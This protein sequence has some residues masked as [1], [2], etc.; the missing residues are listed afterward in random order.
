MNYIK[1]YIA[2]R[3]RLAGYA[4]FGAIFLMAFMVLFMDDSRLPIAPSDRLCILG[5]AVTMAIY[6]GG[7]ILV[8]R[9]QSKL[10]ENSQNS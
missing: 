7:L 2:Y 6:L 10:A 8:R 4:F 1:A 9:H 3:N 5:F